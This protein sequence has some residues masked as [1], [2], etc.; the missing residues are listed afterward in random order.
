MKLFG[1]VIALVLSFGGVSS[2]VA[3]DEDRVT[4]VEVSDLRPTQMNVG[5][6]EVQR[7]AQKLSSMGKKERDAF[8]KA[9]PVPVVVGPSP[10][11]SLYLIDHH[12]LSRAVLEAGGGHVYVKV[13]ADLSDLSR[14]EFW[15]EMNKRGYVYL[16]ND[17]GQ[18]ILPSDLPKRVADLGDDP[19]RSLAGVVRRSGGYVKDMTPFAEFKWAA[20]FRERIKIGDKP[21]NTFDKAVTKAMQ[22]VT[23]P[24]A[25]GLPGYRYRCEG[26][27]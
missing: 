7:K 12:H 11:K 6:I 14:E 16:K 22:L 4:K 17:L 27:L 8:L 15:V 19:Y 10:R 2:A 13:V 3:A 23:S 24:E 26:V 25:E 20:F 1:T 5:M 18:D 9:N 21:K